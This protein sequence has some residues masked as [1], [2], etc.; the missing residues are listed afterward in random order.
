MLIIF[1][2][3]SGTGKTA[4]A[5]EAARQLGAV[6]MRIDSIEQ[7]VRSSAIAPASVED[8]GYRAGYALAADNLKLGHTVV[9]D[10]VNPLV[11]TREAWRAV[12]ADAGVDALDVEVVCSDAV[13]HRRRV[14]TRAA[15]IAGHRL[16]AWDEVVAR[17][18]EV[19][20]GDRLVLDSAAA[21][22]QDNVDELRRAVH[23]RLGRA[24]RA[25]PARLLVMTGSMGA[26]KSTVMAEA[27]DIL[28][29]AGI[30]HAAVDLDGLAIVHDGGRRGSDLAYVNLQSLWRNFA[31]DGIDA[32]LVAA[33]VE[34]QADLDRLR[35]AVAAERIVV[36]RVRAPI[37]V[38]QARVRLRE[39]GMLQAQLVDRVAVLE[40][41][42]DAAGLEDFSIENDG[43]P[44]TAV[45]RDMLV[46]AGWI[47]AT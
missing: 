17:E 4:I 19:W 13:E 36:C 44:V 31:A 15:D 16:P 3:R 25:A 24:R 39:P 32:L 38:M 8:A 7:A 20:H 37:A 27:S 5:R 10:S 22:V 9:A 42:L 41:V 28:T 1:S 23:Q 14:E 47:V 11:L 21:S 43:V 18:Y 2:G 46:R 45:A 12:A 30:V 6:Y 29:A 33:A 40:Q 26:G 35:A 34:T